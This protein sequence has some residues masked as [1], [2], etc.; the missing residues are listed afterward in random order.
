MFEKTQKLD[1]QDPNI[2]Y[3]ASVGGLFTITLA[4]VNESRFVFPVR[5]PKPGKESLRVTKRDPLRAR[6][7]GI[8]RK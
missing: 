6:R 3:A 5:D 8:I 1:P 4:A 2:V 7:N